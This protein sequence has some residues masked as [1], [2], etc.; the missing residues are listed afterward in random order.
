MVRLTSVCPLSRAA[1]FFVLLAERGKTVRLVT[2]PGSPHFPK[3][4]EQRR[5]IFVEIKSWLD[6]FNP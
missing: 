3:L 6:K 1:N 5:N 2:C 4:A